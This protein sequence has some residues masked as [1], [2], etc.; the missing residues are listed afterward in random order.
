MLKRF[1]SVHS[2][3]RSL[4]KDDDEGS[5]VGHDVSPKPDGTQEENSSPLEDNRAKEESLRS[6]H[7]DIKYQE[8]DE[9]G[10]K[11]L[12]DKTGKTP[13]SCSLDGRLDSAGKSTQ[14]MEEQMPYRQ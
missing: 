6:L 10:K 13:L 7:V 4:Q 14:P 5:S 8:R 3:I 11:G 1:K 12:Q 2:T 9:D